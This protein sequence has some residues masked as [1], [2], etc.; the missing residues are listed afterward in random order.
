MIE[1]CLREY[2]NDEE[3]G[4][5]SSQLMRDTQTSQHATLSISAAGMLVKDKT[6]QAVWMLDE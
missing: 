4:P 3:G 2:S 5:R 6:T 1:S